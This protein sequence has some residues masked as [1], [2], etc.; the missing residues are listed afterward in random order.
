M[1]PEGLHDFFVATAGVAGAL[2]GLLFVAI[3]V[4]QERLAEEEDAS[5]IHRVRARAA[6]IAFSNALTV[7]AFGLIPGDKLGYAASVVAGLGFIFIASSLL[8]L[9][10]VGRLRGRDLR[11]ALFL[12]G[13][14]ASLLIQLIAGL[15]LI[16]RPHDGGL[17]N[18]VAV[19]VVVCFQFGIARAWE[20]IGGPRIGFG[21]EVVA[22]V[23]R[24][25]SEGDD[26]EGDDGEG[27]DGDDDGEAPGE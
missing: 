23:R 5:Q 4:S 26:G 20:L 2:I 13:L 9:L 16:Q 18:T 8:A 22:L 14:A 10:R 1:T 27:G 24:G 3:S 21:H 17:A 19:M 25:A 11:E 12:V 7:S 6:L 15:A